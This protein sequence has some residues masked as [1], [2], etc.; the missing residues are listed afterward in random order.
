MTD[1]HGFSEL[2]HDAVTEL[3]SAV[4]NTTMDALEPAFPAAFGAWSPAATV[5]MV[6]L[7]IAASAAAQSGRQ[8][9]G[10][11]LASRR[12]PYDRGQQ[13]VS[14]QPSAELAEMQAQATTIPLLAL[15]TVAWGMAN[16]YLAV[17][18]L[19]VLVRHVTG[20]GL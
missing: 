4:T 10:A 20:L 14:A 19:I 7:L 2:A 3:L 6:A 16:A 17:S 15:A 13:H 8:R 1:T 9:L 12:E 11:G 5:T 18:A